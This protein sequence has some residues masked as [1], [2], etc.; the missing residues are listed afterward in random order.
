MKSLASTERRSLVPYLKV[1]NGGGIYL[2]AFGIEL[3]AVSPIAFLDTSTDQPRMYH[4]MN[5]CV[6][7]LPARPQFQQGFAQSDDAATPRLRVADPSTTAMICNV[8]KSL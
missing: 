7:Q 4:L 3:P 2:L 6:F 5:Q 8:H 1:R